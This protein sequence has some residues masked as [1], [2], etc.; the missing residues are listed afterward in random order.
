LSSTPRPSAVV[1]VTGSEL[2][3]GGKTDA[4]GPF[5]AR[6]L[7]R[8][9]LDPRRIVLVGD[10]PDDLADALAEGLAADLCVV[11]GGLGPTHDDRTV[12]LLA[13]ATGRP[14]AADEALQREIDAVSR[15]IAARL[16]RP[17]AD[18]EAG[19]RKQAALPEGAVSLGL[20][21]T[22][23]AVLLDHGPGVA[24]A[25]PGPPRELQRLWPAVLAS[26][27]VRSILRRVAAPRHRVLRF[28][29]VTESAVA[30]ALQ[31]DA[32]ERA[33]LEVTVCAANLEIQV[34]LYADGDAAADAE[35]VAGRLRER[36]A[37]ELFA[38]DERPVAELVLELLRSRRLTLATAE[39]C[40]G[41]LVGARLT[42]VPGASE[43]Y[44]GGIVAY[45][46][47][48]KSAGLRVPDAVLEA[49][50]AVSAEAAAA[51]ARGAR[52]ALGADVA[53]AVTGIAGPGG[54]TPAKPVGLVYIHADSADGELAEE[55][56]LPGDR[57]EIRVRATVA[58]LHLLRRLLSRSVT[59]SRVSPS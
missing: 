53:V 22:A 33:G 7:T 37:G 12:E 8:L 36:F 4:N 2:V 30:R 28:F 13:H 50:G 19:V 10:R 49:H 9:G 43:A 14:L 18:F 42:A 27:P 20:A 51:M 26:E 34:D 39:S 38:E 40:T 55:L 59:L 52:E 5:L 54:G 21:G 45:A 58:A 23:P 6:E 47:G 48:V 16:G 31:E 56:R 35:A 24:V 46:N 1:V 15:S 11:S 32:G 29:G 17:Y 25:L 41:G 3:R 44:V 57:E